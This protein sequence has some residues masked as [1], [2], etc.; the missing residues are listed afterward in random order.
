MILMG[1]REPTL[2]EVK[3]LVWC[4]VGQRRRKGFWGGS[5]M[6]VVQFGD[7]FKYN[8]KCEEEMEDRGK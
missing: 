8:E 6:T 2:R 4:D 7:I 5:A 3:R 1:T